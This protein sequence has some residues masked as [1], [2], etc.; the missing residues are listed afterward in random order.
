MKTIVQSPSP[1]IKCYHSFLEGHPLYYIFSASSPEQYK[2]GKNLQSYQFSRS[3]NQTT[4]DFSFTI[5]EETNNSNTANLFFD[6][7]DI[8]DVITIK[9]NALA[10]DSNVDFYGVVTN[11]SFSASANGLQKLISIQGKSIE[12]LFETLTIA[13][14]VTAMSFAGQYWNTDNANITLK[15]TQNKSNVSVK[16]ALQTIYDDFV[17]SVRKNTSLSNFRIAD[18]IQYWYSDKETKNLDIFDVD[19]NLKFYFPIASNM[20]SNNAVNYISYIRGILPSNVYEMFGTVING[21]PK[22]KIRLMPFSEKSWNNL[23]PNN[24][25]SSILTDYTLQRSG[26][27]VYTAFLAYIQGSPLDPEF[28]ARAMGTIK[29]N[30]N[31]KMIEKAQIYGYKP[32]QCNFIGYPQNF[33]KENIEVKNEENEKMSLQEAVG[34][35]TKTMA[36]WYGNLDE[37]YDATIGIVNTSIAIPR[38]GEKIRFLKGEFYITTETHTWNYGAAQKISY[39]CERGGDYING[40]FTPLKGVSSALGELG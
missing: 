28:M 31:A 21:K 37:M 5:K 25:D 4:G 20:Y 30:P 3:T 34:E 11:I 1:T 35:L 22:I 23:I 8:F 16:E 32:L 19:D 17:N 6:Y 40:K 2:S 9:E 24:I 27:E 39:Q 15:L 13:T 38:I 18:V 36:E 26:E 33:V 10:T 29:G 12:Y 14:D 7:V